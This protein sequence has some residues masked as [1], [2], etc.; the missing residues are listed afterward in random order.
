MRQSAG[1]PGGS[2]FGSQKPITGAE[3]ALLMQNA[4]ALPMNTTASFGHLEAALAVM[5]ENGISL[6]AEAPL[7]RAD[8]AKALY[9]VSKL[10]PNAPGM[11]VFRMQQ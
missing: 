11:T 9:Q 7:T 3:A 4:L 2:V 1:W 5:A 8:A 6:Q 10:A